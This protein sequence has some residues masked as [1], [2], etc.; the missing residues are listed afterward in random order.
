MPLPPIYSI[1]TE[2]VKFLIAL[3]PLERFVAKKDHFAPHPNAPFEGYYTRILTTTGSTILLIFSS[4]FKAAEHPHFVHFSL[5]PRNGSSEHRIVVNKFPRITDANGTKHPNSVHEFSRV[6]KG[7]GVEGTYR[8]CKDEQRYR[9]ELDTEEFGK[10][11]VSVDLTDRKAWIPG[12][13]TSTPE[14]IFAKLIFLLPLHWNVWSTASTAKYTVTSNGKQLEA[15]EG[16]AHIEKNWGAS[17]PDGWTWVQG[18]SQS[19]DSGVAR[20]ATRTFVMT[21]GKTTGSKAYLCGYRSEKVE[22]SFK[23]LWTLMPFSFQTMFIKESF[24]SKQGT[25]RWE[26]CGLWQRLVVEA[27]APSDHEGW[28]GLN[29]PISSG[30][31]NCLAYES[32]DGSVRVQAYKRGWTMGWELVEETVFDGAAVEFGGDYS[33]KASMSGSA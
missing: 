32:F 22:F 1:L 25:G 17:F 24:D 3:T 5:L 15:G 6:A 7:D 21:G 9:L 23:P 20:H 26:F 8:I 30:H 27:Q 33:F 11:E 18:F 14:G 2:P 10:L 12:N 29:C 16:I 13:D 19:P 28:I 31:N 4:V